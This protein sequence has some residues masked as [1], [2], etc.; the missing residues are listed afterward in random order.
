MIRFYY[1]VAGIIS[2]VLVIVLTVFTENQ[3]VTQYLWL[4]T[5]S[6]SIFVA[7]LHGVLS[8]TPSWHKHL[9][10]IYYPTLMG[11]IFGLLLLIFIYLI[12]PSFVPPYKGT[13]KWK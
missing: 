8:H 3:E 12:L 1:I 11:I 9:G 5:L 7:S 6:Y 10:T 2:L 13:F 4:A